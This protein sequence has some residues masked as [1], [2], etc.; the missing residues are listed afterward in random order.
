M[1][2]EPDDA[3]EAMRRLHRLAMQARTESRVVPEAGQ[4]H[5]E[6][7]DPRVRATVLA[8]AARAVDA[9]PRDAT[10]VA[11]PAGPSRPAVRRW[12]L[13]A[14]ALVLVSVMTGLVVSQALHD[15]PERVVSAGSTA[16][17]PPGTAVDPSPPSSNAP[18]A[19]ATAPP[20]RA[21][22]AR[23][24]A[25]A[26]APEVSRPSATPAPL[27]SPPAAAPSPKASVGAKVAD[28]TAAPSSTS[29]AAARRPEAVTPSDASLVR[30]EPTDTPSP[31]P[32]PDPPRLAAPQPTGAVAS[33]SASRSASVAPPAAPP[34]A[35]RAAP[36]P[37]PAPAPAPSPAR[38]DDGDRIAQD[39]T[40]SRA[41]KATGA[42]DDRD[43]TKPSP[44]P[45]PA[46]RAR[47]EPTTPQAWLER[48]V[49]LRAAGRDAEADR[50]L[51]L[52]HARYP[53]FA[54]PADARRSAAP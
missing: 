29:D 3:V 23:A 24:P 47:L 41:S 33:S 4:A 35:P 10:R 14:A 7:P 32:P 22:S 13:S 31:T 18:L 16:V 21:E 37:A 39:A 1:R 20:D 43:A 17:V 26:V 25:T 53:S 28:R 51:D 30:L 52:L 45:A 12:P 48:I 5:D 40:A 19:T 15:A 36:P 27:Q 9:R 11:V 44:P 6:R 49:A 46:M 50:E 8:A 38:A 34:A 54:I 42:R 2:S